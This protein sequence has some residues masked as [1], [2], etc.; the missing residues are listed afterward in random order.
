MA[1]SVTIEQIGNWSKKMDVPLS[2]ALQA[3]TDIT[4]QA[5]KK[6]VTRAIILMAKS[7]KALTKQSRKNLKVQRFKKKRFVEKVIKSGSVAKRWQFQY[8]DEKGR[9]WEQAKLITNRGLAKKSWMWG[10]RSLP[11]A[12]KSTKPIAGTH[13]LKEFFK[14]NKGG[15][16]VK[17]ML[18]Y[19]LNTT[20]GDLEQQVAR[21]ASNQIMATAAKALERRYGAVVPR[22]AASRQKRARKKLERAYKEAR[23]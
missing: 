16:V 12:P 15:M 5:G 1:S 6:A 20:P 8:P 19:I 17:N 7:A 13:S 3:T 4:G 23:A 2:N 21:R 18:N 9:T 10:I 11:R 22:L 14:K